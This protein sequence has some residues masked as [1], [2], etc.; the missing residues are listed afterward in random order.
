MGSRSYA[1]PVSRD[2][3]RPLKFAP[4]AKFMTLESFRSASLR[5]T[6]HSVLLGSFISFSFLSRQK[7]GALSKDFGGQ[8][9]GVSIFGGV[10]DNF[11]I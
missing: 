5:D 11:A 4:P 6:G 8:K 7:F 10:S 3:S 1:Q 2:R 9:L